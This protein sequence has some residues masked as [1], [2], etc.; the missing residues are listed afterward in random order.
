MGVV[1]IR[2]LLAV[3]AL[4]AVPFIAIPIGLASAAGAAPPA[5]VQDCINHGWQTLTDASGQPFTNQ[6]L[7]IDYAIHHPVSLADLASSSS[8]TGTTEAFLETNGCNLIAQG[9]EATYP[10]STNVGSVNLLI[11]GCINQT[12]AFP[13][14]G[15]YGLGPASFT[16]STDVGTLSGT[17]S[18]PV[19]GIFPPEPVVGYELTLTVTSATGFFA[20]TTGSLQCDFAWGGGNSFTGTVS[21]P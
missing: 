11:T 10:G 6:G 2:R 14:P 7:C 12:S 21:V 18:G 9:F 13:P 19:S 5:P 3:L 1:M 17:A 8:V 16:I 15:T 20:G 4:A